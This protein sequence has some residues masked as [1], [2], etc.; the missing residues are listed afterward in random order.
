VKEERKEKSQAK[1]CNQK[2]K[3]GSP[4]KEKMEVIP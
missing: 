3:G 2:E 4:E 1:G